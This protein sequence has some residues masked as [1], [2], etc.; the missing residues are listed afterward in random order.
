MTSPQPVLS[1]SL[2]DA[3][4][5][6]FIRWQPGPQLTAVVSCGNR[7]RIY[8]PVS[9]HTSTQ[10]SIS[11]GPL[12]WLHLKLRAVR[13]YI[14]IFGMGL[15]FSSGDKQIADSSLSH[16]AFGN[17]DSGHFMGEH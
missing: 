7:G 11:K 9:V 16:L 12:K 4:S 2:A 6:G 10:I 1:F 17:H 14:F 13:G 5:A 3:C 8:Q 15:H